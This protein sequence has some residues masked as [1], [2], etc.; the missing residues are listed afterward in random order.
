MKNLDEINRLIAA[1]EAELAEP[2]SS[3]SKL[4]SRVAELQHEK[5][6][7]LQPSTP[8]DFNDKPTVTNNQII[9][10]RDYLFKN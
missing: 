10:D 1:A 6:A 5:A 3:R 4:L 9:L 2:E 8:P 7:L